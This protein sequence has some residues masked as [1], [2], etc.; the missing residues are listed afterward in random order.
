MGEDMWQLLFTKLLLCIVLTTIIAGVRS[1]DTNFENDNIKASRIEGDLQGVTTVL[2]VSARPGKSIPPVG[3]LTKTARTFVQDGASTE[4]ATQVLGTTL[5]N[6]RLYARIL[7]T[8]SRVF[9]DKEPSVDPTSPYVV[10]P[11][12]T[13]EYDWQSNVDLSNAPIKA[14]KEI[15]V[16]NRN[17]ESL[18]NPSESQYKFNG[19]KATT[20]LDDLARKNDIFSKRELGSEIQRFKPVKVRPA[21]Y[22]PTY[23]VKQE[24]V[25]NNFDIFENEQPK[26]RPR[27][28]KIFKPPV[29]VTQK[30]LDNKPL[31]TV[32]YHGFADFTTTVGDTVIVFSPSTSQAPAGRQATTIKGDATLRPDDG[33][34]VVKIRPTAVAG[35]HKKTESPFMRS[36]DD[37]EASMN[38]DIDELLDIVNRGNIQPSVVEE[39]EVKISSS[40]SKAPGGR[41]A[42]TIKNDATLKPIGDHRK[43]DLSFM[44]PQDHIEAS[45]NH[46][47]DEMLGI[48]NG[49]NIQP[50]VVE[51][52]E[53]DSS[54][55]STDP[56]LLVPD[57]ETNS[58]KP[59]GLL[60]IIDSTTSSDGTT[61]R[62]K[63]LIYGTY[64]GK[65]YTQLIQT[66]SD[67]YFFPSTATLTHEDED[68]TVEYESTHTSDAEEEQDT[69]IDMS[70]STT[71]QITTTSEEA[72]PEMNE[73]TTPFKDT[74]D[75]IPITIKDI[76]ER[77]RKVFDTTDS[78]SPFDDGIPNDILSGDPQGRSIKGGSFKDEYDQEKNN[79]HQQDLVDLKQQITFATKLLPSTTYKTFTYLMTFF[80]PGSNGEMTTSIRPREVVSSEVT[81]LTELILP[82]STES[83]ILPTKSYSSIRPQ[84]TLDITSQLEPEQTTKQDEEIE[85]IFKTL[86]TTYTYLTT[87]FQ[88][89]TS[90]ISSREVVETNVITQ[91]VGPNGVSAAVADLF[92]KDEPV[93][94][95]P[96]EI[97][98]TILPS[99]ITQQ[100]EDPTTTT[101]YSDFT[102]KETTE[103]SLTTA[104]DDETTVE[105]RVSTVP[106]IFDEEFEN[107]EK[108]ITE[109]EASPTPAMSTGV[110]KHNLQTYITTYTYFTTTF[111]DDETEIETRTEVVTNVVTEMIQPSP[112]VPITQESTSQTTPMPPTNKPAVP[113]EILAYL[114]AIQRQKSQEEAFLLAKKVQAEASSAE[115]VNKLSDTTVV[116]EMT[117]ED[118]TT[119]LPTTLEQHFSTE[120]AI[121]ELDINGQVTPNPPINGEILGSMITDVLSSSSSGGGTVLDVMDK[122]NAVPED[123]ELSESNH[124]DV[125]PPP[126]LLLQ[127]SYT[128][129]TYF[130]TM[131][132]GDSSNVASRLETVTNIATET[133]RPTAALPAESSTLPV[134]Y[135]TTFTYWTT[136]YKG[137]DTLTTSREETVSTVVTP[138]VAATPTVQLDMLMTYRPDAP[139]SSSTSSSL[140]EEQPFNER[141]L[142][143]TADN[144][145]TPSDLSLLE[146]SVLEP[147]PTTTKNNVNLTESVII[148]PEPTTYYTTYTYFTT[149]YAGN[150]TI[151]NSRLETV[152]SVYYP[153]ATE[154]KPT[155]RAIDGAAHRG[156]QELETESKSITPSKPVEISKTGLVSTVRSSDVHDDITTH[157][158]TDVY[159]TFIDGVYAQIIKSSTSLE[160]PT[161]VIATPV[162]PTGVLS[163]N[164]GSIVDADG[165]TTVYFTT[166]LIGTSIDGAY[167]KFI[168]NSSSTKIDEEKKLAIQPTQ[169][170]RTGLV[171]LIEGQIESDGITTYYESKV[172]GTSID[173]RYAQRI[174]S[175][176]SFASV[177]PTL[178]IAPSSTLPP[179]TSIG[180]IDVSPSPA[181]IQSSLSEDPTTESPDHDE[182]SEEEEEKNEKEDDQKDDRSSR[183]KP[184]LTFSSRTRSFTPAFRPFASRSRPTFNPLR[185]GSQGA[186]TITRTDITP[187]ITATLAGKGNRFASSRGRIS[188]PIG[189][190]SSTVSPSSSRRF[191]G[192]R[193]TASASS[194]LSS[195]TA[196][197]RGRGQSRISP[198]SVQGNRRTPA[199]VRGSSRGSPRGSS[200]AY[201]GA[202]SRYRLGIRA[203]STLPR[204]QSTLRQDDQDNDANEFTTTTLVTEETPYTQETDEGETVTVPLQTTTESSRRSTNPLLRFRRP[205]NLSGTSRTPTTPKPSTRNNKSNS[206]SVPSRSTSSRLS[207]RPTPPTSTRPRQ[208]N[209]GFFPPRGYFGRKQE[210][211]IEDQIEDIE[212]DEEDLEEDP[213]EE[214]G[215]NDYEG[216]EHEDKTT[217][218]NISPN[219]R[220]GRTFGPVPQ[221]RPFGSYAR[222]RRVRRQANQLRSLTSRFRKSKQPT[223][224]KADETMDTIGSPSTVEDTTKASAKPVARYSARTRS[225]AVSRPNFKSPNNPEKS[226]TDSTE[227]STNQSNKP[228]GRIKQNT[229]GNGRSTSSRIKPSPASSNG[230]QFTLR[231]K[232]PS[233]PRSSYKRTQ[234]SGARTTSRT[235]NKASDNGKSRPPRLRNS[236][237]K[238]QVESINS[239]RRVSSSRASS[240]TPNRSGNGRKSSQRGRSSHEDIRESPIVHPD[241]DG[242]ITVTHYVPTEVT[243]PVVNN[244]VTE[245]R[246]IITAHPS[247]EVLGPSQYSTVTGGDGRPLVVIVSEATGI[248]SQGQTEITRFLLHETPTTR[249]SHTLTTFG[250]RR[251]SQSVIV[252]TTIYSVEHVVSTIRPSLPANPPLANILLSQLLLGQLNP[253]NQLL[254]PQ[255][256]PTTQYNTRTTTYVTTITKHQST[257]IPLTFRG[258]E[259]LTT[260][261]DSSS[262]V[263]TATEFITDTVVVTPT[264]TLPAANLNS[265]LLLLQ[266][267]QQQIQPNPNP[268]LDPVF[269]AAP[270]LTQSNTLPGEVERRHQPA[271]SDYKPDSYEYSDEEMEEYEKPSRVRGGRAR[272]RS[273]DRKDAHSAALKPESSVVTLYVSGRR[274]GEFSTVLSTVKVGEQASSRRRRD[275]NISVKV[276]PSIPPSLHAGSEPLAILTASEDT[277]DVHTPTQSLESVV[278]DVGRHIYTYTHT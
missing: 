251:A 90:S 157:Y 267:P 8:S 163:L 273:N 79:V 172:I 67:V 152:T 59:T 232:D 245:Q 244:G 132:K 13:V 101:E 179:S 129:F 269:A 133:I 17:E 240:R 12:K 162:L 183:K 136:Y 78:T 91:T 247:T 186:T 140:I 237:G 89:D 99:V 54:S 138:D 145:V 32:T 128:T 3:V 119:E 154:Q 34:A 1:D 178:S 256:T 176:S 14:I 86:Y 278:G 137:G 222:G 70:V 51:E 182:D 203:S 188:S 117:T 19:S 43:P 170:H 65:D 45:M 26:V 208:T 102:V 257:V 75:S 241:F 5:D 92:G 177:A 270:L 57:L 264:A 149:A 28:P 250:G 121:R 66:S 146:K 80:I 201:P 40:V 253:Q 260:L 33:V 47:T 105:E 60:K 124:Q 166:K 261:I 271:D 114:E 98:Q 22:L 38:H 44:R 37:I 56:L 24:Y 234:S 82:S 164:K 150:E 198:S 214:I 72:S 238:S 235:T 127:T 85:L 266:Q 161:S 35:D 231:E 130:T 100:S 216:S 243:I 246:N 158:M 207:N 168:E 165:V 109:L 236:S 21:D 153:N 53:I 212:E 223:P 125:E 187:T 221:I 199:T 217:P 228:N 200:S 230:R 171:R 259:I 23:T 272:D 276:Q 193:N 16:T 126:T 252:P 48:V 7:S 184:R 41:P 141:K 110:V 239:S 97:S 227:I 64:I 116:T 69:T 131:Y 73:L 81:Y 4:F 167:A 87:F 62:Y 9:Y 192:R 96:T 218:S 181:V 196:G 206:P 55:M 210:S 151:L 135:F 175:T 104:L 224:V 77:V 93:T 61:T 15:E 103:E 108:G 84:K 190:Y 94:I 134:T 213:V 139:S 29:K 226:Q 174:E 233:Q 18:E 185:K 118:F 191:S 248:N 58:V 219:R 274:P 180:I 202:S 50:S 159:G 242:T 205:I 220:Y 83:S 2:L 173:G 68:T 31:A 249:V 204:G 88:K 76:L 120:E 63:S 36:Q 147:T 225:P 144:E 265:L 107:T 160:T 189:P 258:K 156:V 10:Y 254:Q 74:T 211:P 277:V 122:R 262:D 229:N 255:G 268:L 20:R 39:S 123:Q 46:D 155:G 52:P 112:T 27:L 6:G 95:T 30:K 115:Q 113:P 209:P 42:V 142:K 49:G 169:G 263:I 148:S 106:T 143:V 25:S 194:S 195:A 215:D 111:V 275:A 71:P 11:S 197:S